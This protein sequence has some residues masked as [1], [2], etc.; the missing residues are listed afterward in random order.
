MN[1]RDNIQERKEEVER[2][3]GTSREG[4]EGREKL[5]DGK[6]KNIHVRGRERRRGKGEE[7]NN[8]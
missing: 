1:W 4:N 3:K 5:R 2:C 7:N 8:Y 6:E